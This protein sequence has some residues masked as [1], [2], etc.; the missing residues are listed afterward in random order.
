MTRDTMYRAVWCWPFEF[1]PGK[2]KSFLPADRAGVWVV[3][4]PKE[5][6]GPELGWLR[7]MGGDKVTRHPLDGDI[8]YI[9]SRP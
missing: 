3:S 2:L 9:V 8:I 4:V 7:S 5:L 6:D 1:A